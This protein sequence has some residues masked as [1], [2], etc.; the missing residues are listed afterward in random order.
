M[1]SNFDGEKIKKAKKTQ[2]AKRIKI[3]ENVGPNLYYKD[4]GHNQIKEEEMK[5]NEEK[6]A[7]FKPDLSKSTKTTQY[8]KNIKNEDRLQT[9]G[10]Q[11][12]ED[13][14]EQLFSNP[15]S[16]SK[17]YR[18]Y[19]PNLKSLPKK[20]SPM[21][22]TESVTE[23]SSSS[24]FK[25]NGTTSKDKSNIILIQKG[26]TRD[27]S[28]DSINYQ[29]TSQNTKRI[30][31]NKVECTQNYQETKLEPNIVSSEYNN[32]AIDNQPK[33][34]R[35]YF[36][37]PNNK[38][39]IRPSIKSPPNARKSVNNKIGDTKLKTNK[40]QHGKVM[41]LINEDNSAE[42]IFRL[43]YAKYKEIFDCLDSNKDGLISSKNIG[44]CTLP[45]WQLKALT[46]ILEDLQKTQANMDFKEFC[47]KIGKLLTTQL[48]D[49]N[50]LYIMNDHLGENVI[51]LPKK[52]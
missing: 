26:L 18:K 3:E 34:K 30:V 12:Q 32:F 43:K 39:S 52:Y 20:N 23:D 6:E 28:A 42:V 2:I 21:K 5:E 33:T 51:N 47:L 38:Q 24:S 8:S 41:N 7:T 4:K 15:I 48:F 46:P 22:Y 19:A 25:K 36:K 1:I 27:H 14:N 17:S 9:R 40:N 37:T 13:K 45:H 16:T 10:E 50:D 29:R 35:I 31:D 44:L 49:E 11:I